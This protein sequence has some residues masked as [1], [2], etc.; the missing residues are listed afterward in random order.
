[1]NDAD[2]YMETYRQEVAEHLASIENTVLVLEEHPDDMERINQL[3]RTMH[4]IKG[5]GAMFG[6]DAVSGFAHHVETALDRVREGRLTI[7]R[8]LIDLVLAAR[9]EI[10]HLMKVHGTQEDGRAARRA[11]VVAHLAALIDADHAPAAAATPPAA[12]VVP[13]M[14]E[15]GICFTPDERLFATG[16]DPA[17]LFDELRAL[18]ACRITANTAALPP[19]ATMNPECCYLSWEILIAT[20][21]GVDAVRDVL[22][23]V[24]DSCRLEVMREAT[25][26]AQHADTPPPPNTD[27]P[28]PNQEAGRQG[29][30]LGRASDYARDDSVR[31]P[32][33]RLDRL[34]NLVGELVINQ[35]QLMQIAQ[36]LH[37]ESHLMTTVEEAERL[38]GDLRDD[39]LTMR[40]MPIGTTF[41]R[42]KRLVRDLSAEL[43]KEIDLV[44]DGGETELDKAVL[45]RLSDPL[46]HLV[47]NCVDHGVEDPAVRAAAGKSRRGR[48][49]LAAEHV[50][51]HVLITIEDDG[52]G[53]DLGR[54]RAK[55]VERGLLAAETEL[56]DKELTML[57]FAPGLSTATTVSSVSGRGVGMDVVKREIEALRGMVSVTTKP[58]QGTTIQLSLPLTLAIIDGLLVE[59]GPESFVAP[60][61][62]VEECIEISRASFTMGRESNVVQLRDEL[63]PL[64]SLRHALRLGGVR[65]DIEEVVV[66][67]INDSRVGLVVDRIVGDLQAV[68]K[69]L[70]EVYRH[71]K[72]VSGATILG[73]G[74]VALILDVVTLM[75]C[76]EAGRNLT[77]PCAV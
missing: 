53:L 61:S 45:D 35:A 43:G 4:T 22:I 36:R 50:G 74:D 71:A 59:V 69:P 60:L 8:A 55:A 27:G 51:T 18:G 38:I 47:R 37:N 1:M 56:T 42:F 9:D 29:V 39:V 26:P 63:L 41:G 30:P 46:V 5:S 76:E 11:Q 13:T 77:S 70:G 67:A 72:G 28:A 21:A 2:R 73:N 12:C 20:D 10:A 57:I 68:I 15:Y 16:T 19:L 62:V 40:M 17:L 33:E 34:V 52:K 75:E 65:P 6:F 32:A 54:I 25:P 3:F 23:F 44:T 58:G 66:V 31:V 14:T 49:R 64:I 24:E 48:V 7:S